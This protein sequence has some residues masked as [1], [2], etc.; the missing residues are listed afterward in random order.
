MQVPT[1]LVAAAAAL[2]AAVLAAL[3]AVTSDLSSLPV[4][5]IAAIADAATTIVT[6]PA[7]IASRCWRRR[8]ATRRRCVCRAARASASSRCRRSLELATVAGLLTSRTWQVLR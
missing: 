3:A 5:R 7:T 8:W 2:G 4:S 1:L 6:K